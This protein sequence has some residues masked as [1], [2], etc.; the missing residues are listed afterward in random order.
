MS[1][2]FIVGKCRR[3]IE[4]QIAAQFRKVDFKQK[5]HA[6]LEDD[7]FWDFVFSWY[8]L[9]KYYETVRDTALGAHMLDLYRECG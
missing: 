3:K 8:E 1:K 5:H 9:V 4:D 6:Y 2:K 7:V